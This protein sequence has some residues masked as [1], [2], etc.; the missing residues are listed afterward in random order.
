M[1]KAERRDML[2]DVTWWEPARDAAFSTQHLPAVAEREEHAG[3]EIGQRFVTDLAADLQYL[4][5]CEGLSGYWTLLRDTGCR[6]V[7]DDSD[8][9]W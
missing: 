3:V 5:C 9:V 1:E 6:V 8:I 7:I 2:Q 4:G